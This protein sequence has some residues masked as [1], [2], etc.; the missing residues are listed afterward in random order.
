MASLGVSNSRQAADWA[1]KKRQQ[2]ER[3]AKL[4]A[5]RQ[6]TLRERRGSGEVP[7]FEGMSCDGHAPSMAPSAAGPWR[8]AGGP[9]RHTFSQPTSDLPAAQDGPVSPLP[10]RPNSEAA[11]GE[12]LPEWARDFSTSRLHPRAGGS[13][14]P[15]PA[16]APVH[17]GAAAAAY[18]WPDDM[19]L[20]HSDGGIGYHRGRALPRGPLPDADHTQVARRSRGP[21]PTHR[22]PE[23]SYP[24]APHCAAPAATPRDLAAHAVS[25]CTYSP[26]LATPRLPPRP[27]YAY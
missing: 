13:A 21:T 20:G 3:A 14:M 7:E 10:M 9:V 26:A 1:A 8:G 22:T 12:G 4:K 17:S 25:P 16:H 23:R 18:Y 5:E 27:H 11:G 2:M 24:A 19:P 15:A 6:A